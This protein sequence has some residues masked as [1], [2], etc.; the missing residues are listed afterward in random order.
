MGRKNRHASGEHQLYLFGCDTGRRIDVVE[1][2][3]AVAAEHCRLIGA[4]QG[5]S[6]IH[7]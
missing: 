7:I 2:V 5:L 1:C 6:L 4:L 3:G